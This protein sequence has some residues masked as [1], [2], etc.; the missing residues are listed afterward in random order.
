MKVRVVSI[1]TGALFVLLA[2][3][4]IECLKKTTNPVVIRDNFTAEGM[5]DDS[6]HLKPGLYGYIMD[7]EGACGDDENCKEGCRKDFVTDCVVLSGKDKEHCK[8]EYDNAK[9]GN[10]P[11]SVLMQNCV[12]E[13]VSRGHISHKAAMKK[14]EDSGI[15]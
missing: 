6:G 14:C 9:I 1:V 2:S 5:F 10:D 11:G 3:F 12:K 15:I 4:L 7:C 8:T 13:L